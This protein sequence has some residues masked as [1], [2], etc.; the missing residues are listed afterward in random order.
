MNISL[1]QILLNQFADYLIHLTHLL[2]HY[3]VK[4]HLSL[5]QIAAVRSTHYVR[6]KY[7]IEPDVEFM[8]LGMPCRHDAEVRLQI[9]RN[10]Q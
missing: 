9:A 5:S 2:T 7:F 8:A 6:F 4:S 3:Q 10:R 1:Y